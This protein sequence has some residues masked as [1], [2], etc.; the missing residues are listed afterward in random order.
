MLSSRL[1]LMVFTFGMGFLTVWSIAVHVITFNTLPFGSL[2]VA[3]LTALIGGFAASALSGA[4]APLFL[5]ERARL[6]RMDLHLPAAKSYGGKI[7]IITGCLTVAFLYGALTQYK[8]S[9]FT[10]FWLVCMIS[11]VAALMLARDVKTP[12]LRFTP[13]APDASLGTGRGFLVVAALMLVFYFVTSIPDADDSLLLNM[14]VGAGANREALYAADTMLGIP[15]LAFMKSTYRLEAFQLLAALISDMTGLQVIQSAHIVIPA[16]ICIWSASIL[17][18]LHAALFGRSFLATTLFHLA[19]LAALDGALESYGYHA[20][21]RFFHGKA[22]FVTAMVPLIAFLTVF[23]V[24]HRNITAFLV[25]GAAMIVSLG[26]TA[27]ALYAAP[28]TAA[29][30]VAPMFLLGDMRRKLTSLGLVL[31]ILYPAALAG[32]LIFFDPPEPSEVEAVGQIGGMFWGLLGA[33]YSHL[34][35]LCLMFGAA[36]AAILNRDLRFISVY[37]LVLF[38]LIL[39]PYLWDFYGRAVTGN[40]NSRLMWAVPVP[41][42]LAILAGVVWTS[43]VPLRRTL[44]LVLIGGFVILPG[45]VIHTAQWGIAGLK[46]PQPDYAIAQQ[47]NGMTQQDGL[48]L[49]PE[50]ISTW[51]PTLDGA[52]AVVEGRAIYL[53]QRKKQLSEEEY[54]NRATA[55]GLLT[56]DVISADDADAIT[57]ALRALDVDAIL[58]PQDHP[59]FAFVSDR[60]AE[61]GYRTRA[62][63]DRYVLFV[64]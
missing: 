51:I 64:E 50:E 11:A 23:A 18:L 39:N 40:L 46:I 1:P 55:L 14:A 42:I 4:V 58:V 3:G 53:A 54:A 52:R 37:V 34:A 30:C 35:G 8:T 5:S 56:A 13:Q 19:W 2:Y 33:N 22:A 6:P 10:P 31:V 38:A 63:I 57:Q 12:V 20:I 45:S 43:S 16:L 21:P 24:R 9:A 48:I 60:Q 25:L 61:L 47:V 62:P 41:F 15:D 49:A 44:T 29:L 28:L 17:S 27:N 59:A 36:M 7:W 26:L 32:V